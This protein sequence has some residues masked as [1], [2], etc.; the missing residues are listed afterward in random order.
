MEAVGFISR[1]WV[2]FDMMDPLHHLNNAVY[3]VLFERARFD[4]W[5]AHGFGPDSPG[6]DWPYL[7]ARNEIDYRAAIETEQEVR[8]TVAVAALGHTSITFAHEIYREDGILAASGNTVL[9]RVDPH[10]RRPIP[11]S[12]EF[13]A[14]VAPYRRKEPQVT[15]ISERT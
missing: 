8:V 2:R 12:E 13:R 9:V 3:L 6:F 10:E 4:L 1:Q 14:L 11:W 7:V 15:Q 5:R